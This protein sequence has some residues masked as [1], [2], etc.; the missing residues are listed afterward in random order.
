MQFFDCEV[1]STGFF[2]SHLPCAT[3]GIHNAEWTCIGQNR[4]LLNSP[5]SLTVTKTQSFMLWRKKQIHGVQHLGNGNQLFLS[6]TKRTGGGTKWGG[7]VLSYELFWLLLVVGWYQPQSLIKG[8]SQKTSACGGC[9]LGGNR[10][11]K[12]RWPWREAAWRD[13]K[14]AGPG[15]RRPVLPQLQWSGI[16]GCPSISLK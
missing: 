4:L 10:E 12:G 16:L 9:R 13:V 3:D 8:M 5:L 6:Y 7:D 1:N 14:G 2:F 15:V 11:I